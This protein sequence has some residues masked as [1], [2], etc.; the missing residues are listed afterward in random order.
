MKTLRVV[1]IFYPSAGGM[2]NVGCHLSQTPSK[3]GHDIT[4][5]IDFH[6]ER[7]Y[8]TSLPDIKTYSAYSYFSPGE[9]PLLMPAMLSMSKNKLNVIRI[10]LSSKN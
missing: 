10:G 5:T 3:R 2:T 9:K 4:Y 1:D 7:G 6:L 8:I